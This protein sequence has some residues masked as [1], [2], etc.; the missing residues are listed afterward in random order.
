MGTK[1]VTVNPVVLQEGIQPATIDI[2]PSRAIANISFLGVSYLSQTST[3]LYTSVL[4]DAF[5]RNIDNVRTGNQRETTLPDDTVEGIK[6]G[7]ELLLDSFLGS[8]G[9]AQLVLANDTKSAAGN[10]TIEAV[11]IGNT[12]VTIGLLSLVCAVFV[13]TIVQLVIL[14][15]FFSISLGDR[16]FLDYKSAIVGVANGAEY[17]EEAILNWKGDSDDRRVG[18]LE[19]ITVDKTGLR[20][21]DKRY[22]LSQSTSSDTL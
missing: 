9:A 18:K 1:E 6:Q 14:W 3:T 2:D 13:G 21:G 8:V 16:D 20:L 15:Q 10:V 12:N 22:N 11:Q 7:L 4:G 5:K 19:V 17:N